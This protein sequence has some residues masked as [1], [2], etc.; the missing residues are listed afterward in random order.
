MGRKKN[1]TYS[2]P[3]Q[4]SLFDESSDT[5]WPDSGLPVTPQK[6]RT[7]RDEMRGRREVVSTSADMPDLTMGKSEERPYLLFISFGSGSSGNCTYVGTRKEGVLIDAGVAGDTVANGL[8]DNGLSMDVVKAIILTHDHSD[9]VRFA[10][11]ILRKY[12]HIALYCTP[13]ALGG[14][15]R[16][17]SISRRIKDYHRPFFKEFPFEVGGLKITAFETMHDGTDNCGFFIQSGELNFCVATD[18]GCVSPRVEYYMQQAQFV[19]LEANYDPE[20][21]KNGPYPQHLKARIAFDNGHLSNHQSGEFLARLAAVKMKYVFLCHLSQDNNTP[22][23][24][25]DT[26][27]EHLHAAGFTEVGY[28]TG[29]GEDLGKPIQLVALPRFDVSPMYVLRDD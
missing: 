19:M 4:G 25:V 26:V 24:A 5:M 11:T 6:L 9:H 1:T 22:E 20:M 27:T 28:G 17:H 3:L 12:R 21:L 2:H 7:M 15:L 10:Y 16:R 8:K 13:K 18:L 14:L 29:I 23:L